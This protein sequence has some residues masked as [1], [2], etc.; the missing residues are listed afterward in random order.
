LT[1]HT[2]ADQAI[3]TA[4]YM[5][6]EQAGYG[7]LDVDTRSDVY[8]LGVMLYELLASCL[9]VDPKQVG[10]ARFLALLANGDLRAPE[11]SKRI[12]SLEGAVN[13]AAARDTTTAGLGCELQGDL[14]WIVVK[15]LEVDRAR[16]YETA[17]AL[18][19]DLRR[20]LGG[21]PVS[22]HPPTFSSQ[23]RKFIYRHK[24]QVAGAALL[25]LAL[26]GGTLG[27]TAGMVRAR[28]AEASARSEAATAERYSKF[29]V[30]M[31]EAAAPEHSKGRDIGAREIL[32]RGRHGSAKNWPTSHCSKHGCS[33]RSD[34]FTLGWVATRKR[35]QRWMRQSH[36]RAGR[37]KEADSTSRKRSSVAGR[38]SCYLDEPGK[39]ESDDREALA[40]LER[41]F[42]PNHINVEPVITELG[43]LL[44][45]RDP[46]QALR[47]YRHSY[48]L[49]TAAH[50]DGDGDA[51][52]L[53]QNIGSIHARAGRF[54]EAK[55][56]Y[57]RALPL[58]QR[59]FGQRDYHVGSVIGNLSFVYRNLGDYARAFEMAQAASKSTFPFPA[60]I[61]PT[62]ASSG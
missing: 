18:A 22:A 12:F 13:A 16:R 36:W 26:I 3:G 52:V 58:L 56:A 6:P 1:A 15:A 50:G 30:D 60:P 21:S 53:L 47:M 19:E 61:I 33:P 31:F 10:Y 55:E 35:V 44:R 39:A 24:V 11:P 51:A 43:L 45:T 17:E 20:Y 46:E 2:R 59:H 32:D 29:L 5:S 41:A 34:G 40:I 42:G 57:E 9:P 54:Q 25:I 4:A 62:W 28:R 14:D 48:A 8:S 37:A 38:W 49:Q 27:T 23:L 7:Q